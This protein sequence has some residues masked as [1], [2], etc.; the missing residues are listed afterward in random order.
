ME[1]GNAGRVSVR[2]V[3]QFSAFSFKT[4]AVL[5]CGGVVSGGGER[6]RRGM[7]GEVGIP[8]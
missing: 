6:E 4:S 2:G 5:V 7:R 1:R 3:S 8:D